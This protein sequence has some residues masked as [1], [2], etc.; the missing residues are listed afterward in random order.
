MIENTSSSINKVFVD[1][2]EEHWLPSYIED[3]LYLEMCETEIQD[4]QGSN[5][6]KIRRYYIEAAKYAG[7]ISA[8]D[9]DGANAK[10]KPVF[11]IHYKDFT[12]R[13]QAEILLLMKESPN[14]LRR[15]VQNAVFCIFK[16]KHKRIFYDYIENDGLNWSFVAD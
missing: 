16:A 10:Y 13:L 8:G 4:P 7:R 1:I 5:G 14:T 12:S 9:F 15:V 2:K 6:D 3:V 11:E